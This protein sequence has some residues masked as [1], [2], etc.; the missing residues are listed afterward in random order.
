MKYYEYKYYCWWYCWY[1]F[2]C[3]HYYWRWYCWDIKKDTT[4]T[5]ITIAGDVA[6]T[7]TNAAAILLLLLLSVMLPVLV[8]VVEEE[9]D[10]DNNNNNNDDANT[11][12]ICYRRIYVA[13]VGVHFDIK[14]FILWST[15]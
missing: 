8:V 6:G 4:A 1:E 2:D 9:V 12:D 5:T 15:L 10:N 3:Y 11:D 14:R 7:N 13:V